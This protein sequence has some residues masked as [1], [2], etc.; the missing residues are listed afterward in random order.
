MDMHRFQSIEAYLR[1]MI[2]KIVT[3]L[4]HDVV[5]DKNQHVLWRYDFA[6][7]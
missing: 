2:E 7:S 4:V 3:T 1:D 5:Q 6:T